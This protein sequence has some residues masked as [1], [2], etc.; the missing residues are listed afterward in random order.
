MS[1][2]TKDQF[3]AAAETA[4]V[5]ARGIQ[6]QIDRLEDIRYKRAY[7][8]AMQA[9]A[10]LYPEPPFPEQRQAKPGSESDLYPRPMYDAPTIGAP[11]NWTE[12]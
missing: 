4:A 7:K 3:A 2:T 1:A 12:K 9:G 10:R 5:A 8:G 11:E 6:R